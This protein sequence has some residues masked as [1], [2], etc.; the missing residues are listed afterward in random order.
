MVKSGISHNTRSVPQICKDM[1]RALDRNDLLSYPV[2]SV[3]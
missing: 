1:G 2:S 3:V